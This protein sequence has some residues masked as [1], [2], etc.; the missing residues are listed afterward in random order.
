MVS[1]ERPGDFNR[2]RDHGRD[3]IEGVWRNPVTQE[4]KTIQMRADYYDDSAPDKRRGFSD[5]ELSVLLKGGSVP[6]SY[7]TSSGVSRKDEPA[8]ICHKVSQFGKDMYAAQ[9][10]AAAMNMLKAE[11]AEKA[12][13]Q[14]SISSAM[15][16]FEQ[17]AQ[18]EPDTG[19]G[20]DK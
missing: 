19:Y 20:L 10:E 4:V 3:H 17:A 18:T 16:K 2:I 7:V 1:L 13:R 5:E 12:A 11:Q 9:P 14:A 15:E 6:R 8:M